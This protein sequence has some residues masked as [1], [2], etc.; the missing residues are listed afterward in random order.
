MK[1]SI[2]KTRHT[3]VIIAEH[4]WAVIQNERAVTVEDS[5]SV[6]PEATDRDRTQI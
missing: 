5:Q 4:G 3:S 2:K 6:V 1:Q